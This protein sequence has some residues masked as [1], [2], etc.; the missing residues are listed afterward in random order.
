MPALLLPSMP[1]LSRRSVLAA[2]SGIAAVTVAGAPARLGA[3]P[4]MSGEDLKL[5]PSKPV[6]RVM[7]EIEKGLPLEPGRRLRWAVVGL[8]AYALNQIIPSF[9]ESKASRLTGLVSGDRSKAQKMAQLYGV[10]EKNIYGYDDFDRIA[11][12]AD[13]DIVYIIMPN[14]LHAEY[15]IRALKAGKHVC[16]EKPMANTVAECEAMIAAAKQAN[17]Q[18][19]IGYRAQYEPFNLEAM[20]R[21]RD[22][23]L[24]AVRLVTS[25]HGRHLKPEEPRDQWRM[26]KSLAGGGSLYDIGIYALQATR[27]LTAEE[28]LEVS[29]MMSNLKDDARFKEIED[30]VVWQMRFPSG[31]LAHCSSSYS[32]QGVKRFQVFGVRA[33]VTL[34]PA[35]DYYKHEMTIATEK[36]EETPQLQEGNQFAAQMD[37]MSMAV[38]NNTA[39]KTPGEEGLRDVRLMQAI[40]QAARE[41]RT[42]KLG[43]HGGVES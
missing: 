31:A 26:V 11:D 20:R 8:G 24:G 17:R 10:P 14:G 4:A 32:Y 29:A 12:N 9:A 23:E 6:G 41:G 22:G 21:A 19:M 28:P 1:L 5:P 38:T 39:V 43:A 15:A 27:Y 13:I 34:D 3:Q 30:T 2:A 37:H 36:L 40:Y 7:P 35:P 33:S 18:L 42:L 25:D 16:C